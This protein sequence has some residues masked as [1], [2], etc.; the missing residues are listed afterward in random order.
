VGR[1]KLIDLDAEALQ[2]RLLE[3]E[4]Q[5]RSIRRIDDLETGRRIA[6]SREIGIERDP[7]NTPGG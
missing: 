2:Q 5:S 4:V 1:A 3:L 7:G 6:Q